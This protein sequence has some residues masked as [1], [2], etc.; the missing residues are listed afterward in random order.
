M[1]QEISLALTLLIPY[2][3]QYETRYVYS[4][5]NIV[6]PEQLASREAS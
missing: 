4:I 3:K 5:K 1:H 2:I 6:D